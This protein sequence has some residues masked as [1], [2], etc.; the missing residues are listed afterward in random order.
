[1]QHAL[2]R[3]GWRAMTSRAARGGTQAGGDIITDF[4]VCL[5]VKDHARLD[6]PGFW[7]QAVEQAAGDPAGLVVKRRGHSMAEEWWYVSDL[8][9]QLKLVRALMDGKE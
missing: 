3:A 9:T 2:E 4:P 8:Q 6:L 1:M 7:R 5:E